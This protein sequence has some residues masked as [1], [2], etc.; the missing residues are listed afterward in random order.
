MIK[1]SLYII[2]TLFLWL[3]FFGTTRA[4]FLCWHSDLIPQA[5]GNADIFSAF[6]QALPLD[7]SMIGYFLAI[8][9]IFLLLVSFLPE[10]FQI[11]MGLF[12]HFFQVLCF[13][14]AWIICLANMMIYAEWQTMLNQRAVDYLKQP[15]GLIDSLSA[16]T[17]V[18]VAVA[19]IGVLF[20]CNTISRRWV[21]NM[22][23]GQIVWYKSLAMAIVLIPTVGLMIRG[24]LGKMPINESSVYYSSH[25]FLNH[26]ATNPVWHF[27]HTLVERRSTTNHFST[28]GRQQA[29]AIVQSLYQANQD[30][31]RLQLTILTKPNIVLVMMESMNAQIL[32]SFGGAAGIAPHLDDLTHESLIFDS[33]YSTG[34]RTDQGLTALLSGYPAQPDQSVI[35]LEDKMRALPSLPRVLQH[36][37]YKT[38]YLYGGE[39]NFANMGAYLRHVQFEKILGD[40]EFSNHLMRQNWGVPDHLV[41]EQAIETFNHEAEPFFGMVQTLSLHAPYDVPFEH[42]PNT[43]SE[44]DKFINAARFADHSIYTFIQASKAT[45]WFAN[46]L[47]IFVADHGHVQPTNIGSDMPMARKVPLIFYGPALNQDLA[48]KRIHQ[49]GNHNDLAQTLIQNIG[50]NAQGTTFPWSKNLMAKNPNP[51]ATYC[52]ETGIGWL[53]PEASGYFRFEDQKWYAPTGVLIDSLRQMDARAYLQVLYDDFLDLDKGH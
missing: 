14:L 30:T 12:L 34:Y 13:G 17:M 38:A 4:L 42:L 1:K 39:L 7:I 24:G 18:A 47:F 20:V 27:F 43:A 15:S 41:F 28:Y 11:K 48:G 44:S 19:I 40:D 46:T 5:S 25:T 6:W 36:N 45:T 8:P 49:L 16:A 53:R 10:R 37:G 3:L 29:E 33:I 32:E 51:F 9:V 35:L 50:L 23:N 31:T 2:K 21:K 22:P 26:A 52:N